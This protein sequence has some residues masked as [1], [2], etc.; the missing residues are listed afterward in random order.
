[1]PIYTPRGLKIRLPLN[2]SF[3]LMTRLYPE[4][5]PFK[6]LK[7]A[8]ALELLPAAW[9]SIVAVVAFLAVQSPLYIAIIIAAVQIVMH[10][11]RLS[12]FPIPTVLTGP[13]YIYSFGSGYGVFLIL[14]CVL[15]YF[16]SGWQGVAAFLIARAG[17]GLLNGIIASLHQSRIHRSTGLAVTTSE[18]VFLN[19]YSQLA[20]KFGCEMDLSVTDDEL[21][22]GN[23]KE[24]FEQLASEWPEVV[25]R[26]TPD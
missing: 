8:E 26:F 21:K 10:V 17:A 16:L 23:W 9:A 20:R 5:T 19:A 25:A 24:T 2:Y 15:G 13:A 14:I 22:E 18:I 6:F 11:V 1:M 12:A 3:A 7:V 4:V